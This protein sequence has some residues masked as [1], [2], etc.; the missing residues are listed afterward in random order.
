[1]LME[2][3]S[4]ENEK[5]YIAL[6]LI[7]SRGS[8]T[9]SVLYI[10]D[11]AKGLKNFQQKTISTPLPDFCRLP[12]L[13]IPL[14][15]SSNYLLITPSFIVINRNPL[16]ADPK[17][18][19]KRCSDLVPKTPTIWAKW[20]R[21]YR[22]PRYDKL[23]DD[24]FLCR[25]D[26]RLTYV[27]IDN[28]SQIVSINVI[29]Q[30]DCEVDA[31]FDTIDFNHPSHG[32]DLLIAGGST[33]HGGLFIQIARQNPECV[34]RFINWAPVFDTAI[35]P[36]FQKKARHETDT[37]KDLSD[38]LHLYVS[39]A[40]SNNSGAVYEFRHGYEAQ[41]G[42]II[43]L[44]DYTTAQAVWVIPDYLG[45]GTFFLIS[46]PVSSALMH[47]S[48]S[49][50]GEDDEIYAVDGSSLSLD[51]STHTLA[52]GYTS[53]AVMLQITPQ[54]VRSVLLTKPELN[55]VSEFSIDQTAFVAAINGELG[56]VAIALRSEQGLSIQVGIL[57]DDFLDINFAVLQVE[58]EPISIMIEAL[59]D[60]VYVFTGTSDGRIAY[61]RVKLD[62]IVYVGEYMLNLPEDHVSKAIES[63]V[64][65]DWVGTEKAALYCGLRG[66]LL[67]S[68]EAIS[69]PMSQ[70]LIILLLAPFV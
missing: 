15:K 49:D 36:P 55:R 48:R 65:V 13:L 8:R 1:M 10:W 63:I 4:P 26:G 3:L 52:A 70:S 56:L 53:H 40:S 20:A 66:G 28:K 11:T 24:I 43:P 34:Q 61:Y 32:G 54:A 25:E 12:N 16:G 19:K 44:E 29:G 42:M 39:S 68:L 2:F 23:H 27:E 22:H 5:D 21:P 33:G 58:H 14:T 35:V 9:H 51:L 30:L 67:I 69:K 50:S 62:E 57:N 47:L 59:K 38:D 41:I 18:V 46:D 31:A 37:A 17:L 64:L 7:V 6:L 45:D 60:D